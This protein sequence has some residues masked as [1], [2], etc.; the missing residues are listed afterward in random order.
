MILIY[1]G[2]RIPQNEELDCLYANTFSSFTEYISLNTTF[3]LL[4]NVNKYKPFWMYP[5]ISQQKKVLKLLLPF[6]ALDYFTISVIEI[7]VVKNQFTLLS[8]SQFQLFKSNRIRTFPR[9]D[10]NCNFNWFQQKYIL[11]Y[12]RM[13]VGPQLLYIHKLS[14]FTSPKSS[15][16]NCLR[17]L[18]FHLL[19]NIYIW[20]FID[21]SQSNCTIRLPVK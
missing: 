15:D 13:I 19:F 16:A 2:L 5:S 10:S 21:Q 11:N 14:E 1:D 9:R 8:T 3:W 6:Y 7:P 4:S 12:F 20:G 17:I 18:Q